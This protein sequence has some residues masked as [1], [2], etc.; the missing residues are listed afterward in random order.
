MY[1]C[2]IHIHIHTYTAIE[3]REHFQIAPLLGAV[4]HMFLQA[5]EIKSSRVIAT[6]TKILENHWDTAGYWQGEILCKTAL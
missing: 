3:G 1:I 4:I 6:C 2:I 5:C